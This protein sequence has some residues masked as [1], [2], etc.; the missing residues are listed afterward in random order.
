MPAVS[1]PITILGLSNVESGRRPIMKILKFYSG[2]FV[3]V[4]VRIS[5]CDFLLKLGA[6]GMQGT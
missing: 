1:I 4:H 6:R 2:L 3:L 5:Q